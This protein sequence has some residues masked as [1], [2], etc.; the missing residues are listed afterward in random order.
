MT[1]KC[2]SCQKKVEVKPVPVKG[3]QVA[4]CPH[5]GLLAHSSFKKSIQVTF[6]Q[7]AAGERR[8]TIA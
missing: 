2:I 5:C 6:F 4:Q 3:G 7:T 1:V 8:A